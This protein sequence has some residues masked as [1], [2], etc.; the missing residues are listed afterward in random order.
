MPPAL[1]VSAVRLD[2]NA[3]FVCGDR[4]FPS[5]SPASSCHVVTKNYHGCH[6]TCHD[7]NLDPSG[8]QEQADG[9]IAQ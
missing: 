5:S 7:Q 9:S 2:G 3:W 8:T 6:P 1:T 4:L